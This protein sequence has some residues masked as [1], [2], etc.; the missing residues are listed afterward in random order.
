MTDSDAIPRLRKATNLNA[1]QT[2]DTLAETAQILLSILQAASPNLLRECPRRMPRALSQMCP[3]ADL[4]HDFL[5]L[6]LPLPLLQPGLHADHS[7]GLIEE[8]TV[9][10]D[11][12]VGARVPKHL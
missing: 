9:G 2:T 6:Q 8:A 5:L 12:L 1:S 3:S 11:D 4:L 10:L 7:T